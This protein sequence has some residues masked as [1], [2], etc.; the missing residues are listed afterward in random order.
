[1]AAKKTAK[2]AAKPAKQAT[3]VKKP[4]P[5]AKP[6]AKS[7]AAAKK[8]APAKKTQ[9]AK[10]AAPAS[11]TASVKKA[12]P[13]KK[14]STVKKA[15]TRQSAQAKQKAAPPKKPAA[16]SKPAPT[17]QAPGKDKATKPSAEKAVKRV[18]PTADV[19]TDSSKKTG[20]KGTT[21]AGDRKTKDT[22]KDTTKDVASPPATPNSVGQAPVTER[23]N[24]AP[25]PPAN[26]PEQSKEKP[27]GKVVIAT[28]NAAP[29][30]ATEPKRTFKV[31]PYEVDEATGRPI[32]P[33]GYK[34]S[35]DEEYM[36]PLMLEYFRQRLL[37]WRAEL[38]EESKQT[39]ENLREEVR[40]I[41]DEAERATRETENSLELRTRDRY[42]KL[43]AKIDS[44][45]KRIDS[46]DYGYCVDTGEEIGLERMEA[47]LT[48][49][50]TVDAQE[51]W[52]HQQ[53]M[54]GE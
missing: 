3:S 24:T 10:K 52:E 39:I 29:K 43:I 34:P 4:A 26:T 49:E 17:K 1:M 48:A 14:D 46:G 15:A 25:T 20:K 53:K 54:M 36:N 45:L 33:P 23:K 9:T 21:T 47:R 42:R 2:K 30:P 7:T 40:D 31:V 11:K 16:G 37:Q 51:R 44:T 32:V 38:V 12:A 13:A 50:R 22:T 41:G 28:K 27:P 18:I 19:Q 8:A 35:P 6:V 5:A